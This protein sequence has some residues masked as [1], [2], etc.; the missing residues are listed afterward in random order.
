[1]KVEIQKP[2]TVQF[3]IQ[4]DKG[5]ELYGRCMWARLT[6]DNKNWS[7]MAQTD[8]GN[9]S[10]S[11]KP[12]KE[13]MFLE[14]MQQVDGQYLLEKISDRTRFNDA[15]SKNNL[16]MWVSPEAESERLIK[17]ISEIRA[18]SATEFLNEVKEISGMEDYFD[19]WECIES[20]YPTSAKVFTQMFVE[21]V[22]PEIRKYLRQ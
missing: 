12:E 1:M 21:C 10:Y 17:E 8:C 19:L 6:F 3:C 9:Y 4:M 18:N 20:D 5:D 16:I 14:L 2:D 11:W 22:Q 13:R 7:M 15:D